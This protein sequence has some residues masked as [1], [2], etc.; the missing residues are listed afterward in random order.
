M[1]P[2]DPGRQRT[3]LRRRM[4][5]RG[6][7]SAHGELGPAVSHD[8]DTMREQLRLF[9]SMG[10]KAS[11]KALRHKIRALERG[12]DPDAPKIDTR[13]RRPRKRVT[14]SRP[15]R[16]QGYFFVRLTCGHLID[17]KGVPD[18]DGFKRAPHTAICPTCNPS[19]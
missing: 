7:A 17:A 18:R 1:P 6:A 12:I 14:W 2:V 5:P 16:R 11:A 13:D 4:R 10:Y 3:G 8:L 19:P 9:E 15:A